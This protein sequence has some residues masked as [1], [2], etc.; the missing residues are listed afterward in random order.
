[1]EIAPSIADETRTSSERPPLWEM[2]GPV[3]PAK[4]SLLYQIGTLAVAVAM[5]LLPLL[6][7]A[8]IAGVGYATARYAV[9]GLALFEGTGNAKGRLLGVCWSARGR[10]ARG[11]VHDQ[12]ALCPQA[13]GI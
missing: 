4:I 3:R 2:S 5:V 7:I 11:A 12:A 8:L 6:Y 9:T 13:E 1:M 10:S